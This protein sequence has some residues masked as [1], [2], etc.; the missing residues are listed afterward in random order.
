MSD[1]KI[2]ISS[3]FLQH[4]FGNE[5]AL[6]IC[7]KSGFDA[8]DFDLDLYGN[9]D[10]IYSASEDEFCTFFEKARK[11]SDELGIEIVQTHG[12][13]NNLM[14]N[15][16]EN[17]KFYRNVPKDFHASSILGAQACVVHCSSY[18][19]CG[20][21]VSEEDMHRINQS[22]Y[23]YIV[24]FAEKYGVKV[25]LET[26]GKVTVNGVSGPD[27]FADI[28]K[29]KR[30]Y[31]SIDTKMKTFCFDSGHANCATPFFP[32]MTLPKAIDCFGKDITLLHL[33]DNNRMSDQHLIP[34]TGAIRWQQIFAAL[35]DNGYN[36]TYN[37][38]IA[39][40][41]FRSVIEDAMIFLAKY[42]RNFV[43]RNLSLSC[44]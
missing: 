13:M 17:Q 5:R 27:L 12:R 33:H 9:G 43:Q 34:G 18:I 35:L 19:N 10:D 31:D 30:E 24:P 41:P 2:S 15:E 21:S 42:L 14:I 22:G 4:M 38:E 36:G 11:K 39:L 28:N 1:L 7:K 20:Y 25:A 32:E 6:E 3:G 16:D 23:K 8:V 37:F 29:M 26:F 40:Y 44:D